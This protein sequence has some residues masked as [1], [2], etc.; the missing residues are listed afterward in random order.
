M[1]ILALDSAG[2]VLSAA[3]ETESKNG[4]ESGNFFYTE[5]DAGTRHC[6]LLMSCADW[7]CKC[8]GIKPE[9]IDMV[10]CMEGPGSFTGLRIGFSA[11]KGIALALGI[12]LVAVPTLDC[13]A[14]PL[15]FWPG[16][17]VPAMDAKKGCFFTALYR[18]GQRL[19][20]Y[21]DA[22]AELVAA[23]IT[24]ER[25]SPNSTLEPVL[26]TGCGAQML[27][28]RLGTLLPPVSVSVNSDFKT[29]AARGLLK[30]ARNNIIYKGGSNLGPVYLRK[31]DAE[32][33]AGKN[34]KMI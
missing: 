11:A 32:L 3:L 20:D 28:S 27:F 7:L 15:S 9:N 6:E 23:E 12:P 26:F 14:Y 22:P 18:Q 1:N 10:A 19:T 30:I 17:V 4:T 16:I 33:N 2:E 29:G 34:E 13:I 31:S 8:A 21:I 25:R 5:I 24:K